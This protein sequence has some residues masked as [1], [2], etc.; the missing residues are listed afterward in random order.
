MVRSAYLDGQ[1]KCFVLFVLGLRPLPLLRGHGNV[2][3]HIH[4]GLDKLRETQAG[5]ADMQKGLAQ[6]E[7]RLRYVMTHKESHP[8]VDV[9]LLTSCCVCH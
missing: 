1:V 4:L 3:L 7:R 9:L 5:V 6:K 8:P 2:Q